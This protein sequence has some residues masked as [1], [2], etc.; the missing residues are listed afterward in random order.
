MN[1]LLNNGYR[2]ISTGWAEGGGGGVQM[3]ANCANSNRTLLYT[4]ITSSLISHIMAYIK[5]RNLIH[6]RYNA[7][8][9]QMYNM[10][11]Y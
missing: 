1:D 5:I 4:L 3:A 7:R 11:Y 10:I 2:C 8:I 9:V 6:G